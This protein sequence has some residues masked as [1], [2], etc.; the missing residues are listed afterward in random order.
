MYTLKNGLKVYMSVNKD[1]PRIQT[2]IAVHAGAKNEPEESTGLAHYLEHVMFKGT[3]QFGTMDFAKEKPMLD[4][5][6]RLYEVYRKT[7]DPEERKAVYHQIDSVSYEASKLAIP[8]EYD[9]LMATIGSDGSNA[10]TSYDVTCY[11]EDIPSNQIDNWAKVQADRFKNMIIRGFHTELEAVYEEYNGGLTEDWDKLHD[12]IATV[13]FPSHSYRR[14]IIGKQ[15]HLKNPSI[16]NIKNFFKTYYVPNNMAIC[17]SGDFVPDSMIASIERYFGDMEPNDSLKKFEFE[18]DPELKKSV[19]KTVVTPQEEY[20]SIAWRFDGVASR[21][22]DTLRVLDNV[23]C[24]GKAGLFDLNLNLKHKVLEAVSMVNEAADYSYW[25][26]RA[27][28]M[29][30]QS[31][32]E[33]KNILLDEIK[34]LRKGQF[35]KELMEAVINNEKLSEQK[36]LE[37]NSQRVNMMV[38]A[39]INDQKWEDVVNATDREAK[40]SKDDVAAFARQHV[41]PD[42]YVLVYKR[43]G[44]D[45]SIKPV[46]KPAITPIVM[47]RDV[48]SDFVKEISGTKVSP[49]EPVFLDFSKDIAKAETASKL[50]VVYKQNET[51]KL[52]T[53]SFI[54]DMG[55]FADPTMQFAA[56]YLSYLGTDSLTA[57]QVSESFYRLGCSYRVSVDNRRTY[58]TLNGLDENLEKALALLEHLMSRA[59]ADKDAWNT[60]LDAQIQARQ[61]RKADFGSYLGALRQYIMWGEDW[62][63]SQVLS[64]ESLRALSPDSMLAIVKGFA[65]YKHE[66]A[67]YGP[68]TVDEAVKLLN[69]CHKVAATLKEPLTNKDWKATKVADNRVYFVPFDDTM[70]FDLC[71]YGCQGNTFDVTLMPGMRLYQE[72]FGGGMNSIVFQ[73]MREKKAL[74]YGANAR[75]VLPQL[76]DDYCYF[77][78]YAESQSDKLNDVITTFNGIINDMPEVEESFKITKDAII[79]RMRTQRTTGMGVIWDYFTARDR[80]LETDPEAM[81]YEK[82]QNMTL[83]DVIKFQQKYVKG[84]PYYYGI[85]G[86]KSALDFN[87]LKNLGPITELTPEQVFGY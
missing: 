78:S 60:Y 23:V 3:E 86:K 37:N 9:K 38:E 10:Y 17:V 33:V 4:E 29:P 50:P 87:V 16:T 55:S 74:V 41:R 36:R 13:L 61:M 66:V 45:S 80:G 2:A 6:E 11:V 18:K 19:S 7:T 76:K 15:E 68:R 75:Y 82:V 8:N 85:V 26:L 25:E 46:E 62:K 43:K 53:L 70:N 51:N 64:N 30:G 42:N 28:P 59:T 83:D 71:H 65:Q 31:L 1:Q 84:Q 21:Q 72:Y 81:I 40:I 48:T 34:K 32:D 69:D 12:T 73:D 79:A 67:Y 39:F 52:F 27:Y 57:E 56:N 63:K 5:I 14:G 44:T 58:V 22:L 49:I 47:N 54:Y 77:V 24:N 20:V 35:T